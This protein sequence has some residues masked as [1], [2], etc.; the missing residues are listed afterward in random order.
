M[1]EIALM[2]ERPEDRIALRG[3]R[4]KSTVS[5]MSQKTTVDQAFVNL[6]DR[7]IEA[8]YTFPL[9]ENSAVCGF[10][11]VTA[12]R[13][14]TG[15]IDENDSAIETYDSAIDKGHGAFLLEQN[16]PDVFTVRVGNIKPKQAATIRITYVAQ[17]D[18]VDKQIRIA[19]PTTIAPR[20]VSIA[21][22]GTRS[23]RRK[24]IAC[25]TG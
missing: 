3:L 12:D 17:L 7:A 18:R 14:L 4:V 1:K 23:I 22:T 10:E 13:T 2:T 24:R 6:E 20:F 5:G 16:R 15:V 25:R 21:G 11:V 8:I 9:P 19:F